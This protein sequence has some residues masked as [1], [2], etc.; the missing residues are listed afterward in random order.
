M[1]N[2]HSNKAKTLCCYENEFIQL[3]VE[4]VQTIPYLQKQKKIISLFI[5]KI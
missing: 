4:F 1:L 2:F 3:L 5:Y